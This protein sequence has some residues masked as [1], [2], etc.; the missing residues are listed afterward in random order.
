MNFK[1]VS[2]W[3][4]WFAQAHPKAIDLGLERVRAVAARLN[5]LH[6][7]CAIISVAGT[8][9]KGSSVNYLEHIYRAAGY[10][11]G[12]YATPHLLSYNERIRCNG[13]L[14]TDAALCQAFATIDAARQSIG[15]TEF[16]FGTLAAML[17]FQQE[18]VDI[19]LLEVGLGGRLDAV[20]LWDADCALITAI[21]IDHCEYLGHTREHIAV[22]KAGILRPQR[23][24]VCSDPQP[25]HSLLAYAQQQQTPL[26]CVGRD[27]HYQRDAQGWHWY[28]GEG[29]QASFYANLPSLHPDANYAYRN[30]AGVLQSVQLMQELL[31]VPATAI[32][33]GLQNMRLAGRFQTLANAPVPCIVDVAHNPL[34]AAALREALQQQPCSG[35]THLLLGMM[36]DKDIAGTLKE[37]QAVVA[38][39]HL[40]DLPGI[41][42]AATAATL[43]AQVLA[44]GA[45]NSQVYPDVASAYTQLQTHWQAQDRLVVCGS[46]HTVA[47]LLAFLPQ[48]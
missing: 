43:Q 24:A 25:P 38:V 20:N 9:G 28:D 36:Q 30:A 3:L 21:G 47:A 37:L 16:E 46:F 23:P 7:E 6:P 19:A 32:R 14:V 4:T 22:E 5:L 31:P 39:W 29:S 17:L 18:K 48:A 42:R 26:A 13:H 2:A 8:N 27:F 35:Q 10:R 33:E 45:T 1:T 15:L 12:C 11:T 41:A 34:G 44:L 40:V